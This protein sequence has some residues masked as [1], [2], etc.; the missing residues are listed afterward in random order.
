MQFRLLL[1][2]ALVAAG[3]AGA[4]A[5]SFNIDF[6]PADN[7]PPPGYAAAGAAGLWIGLVAPH[8]STTFDLVDVDGLITDVSVRQLGGTQTLNVDDPTVIGEDALLLEDYLVTFSAE[9]ETCLFFEHVDPGIY[10]VLIYAWMPLDPTV[11]SFTSIDQEEGNPHLEVG[12]AWQGAHQ[13]LVTYSRHLVAVGAD[14]ILNMHSGIVPGANPAL[15]AAL[16]A[17]QIRPATEIFA[18]GFESGDASAW[19]A[20]VP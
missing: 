5:E 2:G 8:G 14:G 9:V 6:G 17:V 4:G 15:G 20:V 1:A 10:E 13:E 7:V 11:K 3:A 19:S 12:G 16:N 18:D